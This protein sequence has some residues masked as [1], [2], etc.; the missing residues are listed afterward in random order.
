MALPQVDSNRFVSVKCQG[1]Y[2][3][4]CG[5]SDAVAEC[6]LGI[7]VQARFLHGFLVVRGDISLSDFISYGDNDRNK[8]TFLN[9]YKIFLKKLLNIIFFA[10]AIRTEI[11]LSFE[12]FL[13]HH[14][15]HCL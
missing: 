2:S 14:N 9:G 15:Q 3:E 1:L 11:K 12:K 6:I 4:C 8:H 7:V 13:G 10:L 5:N